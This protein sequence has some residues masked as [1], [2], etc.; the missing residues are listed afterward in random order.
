[1]ILHGS[2]YG[3]LEKLQCIN[4][5]D[6]NIENNVDKLTKIRE[7]IRR[8]LDIAHEKATKI[9]NLRSRPIYYRVGQY[10]YRKNHILSNMCKRI[11]KKFM[12]KFIKCRISKK[13]GNNLY[14]VE[15]LKGKYVGKYHSH[16]LKN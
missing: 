13:F 3:I 9:Y 4:G 6:T 8:N 10:V 2:S 1:M 11:N 15:D 12:P 14:G 7:K 16:D 5:E